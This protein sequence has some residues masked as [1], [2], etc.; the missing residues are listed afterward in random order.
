[1][2]GGLD[3]D[4]AVDLF[5]KF[6]AEVWLFL[7]RQPVRS[8]CR[9]NFTGSRQPFGLS[10]Q[11]KRSIY[12]AFFWCIQLESWVEFPGVPPLFVVQKTQR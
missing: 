4:P 1:M 11:K 12:L 6:A 10:V 5:S 8:H 3:I 7:S 2:P 9:I